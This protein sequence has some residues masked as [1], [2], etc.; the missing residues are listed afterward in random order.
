LAR[1]F[2]VVHHLAS[3]M[4]DAVRDVAEES[5]AGEILEIVVGELLDLFRPHAD[6]LGFAEGEAVL[7]SE[8]HDLVRAVRCVEMLAEGGVL[9]GEA[10][11]GLDWVF[12]HDLDFWVGFGLLGS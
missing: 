8:G 7:G 5:A 2:G 6:R 11:K 4:A 9:F 3:I 1:C 10:K 12:A